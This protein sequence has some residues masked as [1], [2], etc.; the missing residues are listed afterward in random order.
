MA[1]L[2][3]HSAVGGCAGYF[4]RYD[5]AADGSRR[6]FR[7]DV[8]ATT[9]S[10][11]GELGPLRMLFEKLGRWPHLARVEP[12]MICHLPDGTLVR[13]HGDP[14]RWIAECERAFG[15]AGQRPFWEEVIATD[16]RA[17]ELSRVNRTFPPKTPGD[18]LRMIR[19]A[20]LLNIPLL[21]YTWTSVLDVMRRHG[22]HANALF[23]RFIDELLMIT[24]QNHA[25]D[26]PFLI[27]AMGLAYPADTWYPYGGMYA[28]AELMASEI[29]AHGA[30]VLAK[31]KVT[32]IRRSGE[33]WT[34]ETTRGERYTC[35][36]LIA[37]ATIYDMARLLPGQPGLLFGRMAERAG[38]GWGAFTLYCAA[39]D[40]FDDGG[41]LYHQIHTG[42][43]PGCG[44]GAVFLSLSAPDDRLRSPEGWRV[45]T[46]STHIERPWEWEELADEEYERRKGELRDIILR[47]IGLALPGFDAVP[48]KF[49]L[50]GTPRTFRH[51]TGR[52]HGM[53]GGVP[54][55]VRRNILFSPKFRTPL[56]G[57]SL[58]GDTVYPGQ[59]APG[60]VLGALNLVEE[61]L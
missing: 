3:G 53:V 25:D 41:C 14:E 50:A 38:T 42:P 12:G 22:L 6:R 33:R 56:P 49:I 2:E 5:R 29:T 35:G 11:V 1:L 43:L 10:G 36:R 18:L 19:P 21:R 37:N 17:W 32:E 46:V 51:Y 28:L 16:R 57:L 7:F 24:A 8:G 26:T 40:R 9:V 34:L 47:A 30:P 39:E 45:L 55:S 60:V 58:V 52:L 20:N 44:A 59:G 4:D 13:R 48:K 31:R 23:C 61:I 27:G 54:H 15:P